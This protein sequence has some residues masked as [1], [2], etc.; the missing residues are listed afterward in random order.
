MLN[1]LIEFKYSLIAI[2][3]TRLIN[4]TI[5]TCTIISIIAI[6]NESPLINK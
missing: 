4:L 3:T 5:V 1:Y 6:K 2:I